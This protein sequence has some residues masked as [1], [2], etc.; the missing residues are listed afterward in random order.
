MQ[1]MEPTMLLSDIIASRLEELASAFCF[2]NHQSYTDIQLDKLDVATK[3]TSSTSSSGDPINLSESEHDTLKPHLSSRDCNGS[4]KFDQ[5]SCGNFLG[6]NEHV[7]QDQNK[8]LKKSN[9][10]IKWTQDLHKQFVEC[11]NRLGGAEK[12]T[13]KAILKLMKSNELT[14]YHVKS[15]L[16]KYRSEKYKLEPLQEKPEEGVCTSDISQLYMK[17]GKQIREALQ[18]QLDV[19]KHLH[20]QLEIQQNLQILMEE[21]GKQV[22]IMLEKQQIKK[23]N[24]IT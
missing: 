23:R 4:F 3:T 21:Q 14:I 10:R 8:L 1:D 15:H 13:P 24:E 20:H 16:Q 9:K 19:Q 17:I 22:K 11:V 18:M 12:A 5:S 2:T 6:N 7:L